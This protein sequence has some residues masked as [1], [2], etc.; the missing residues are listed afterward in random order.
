[1]PLLD[2]DPFLGPRDAGED[3]GETDLAVFR[4]V[5]G[6]GAGVDEPSQ[7]SFERGPR[8]IAFLEFF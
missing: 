1:M 4:E 8:A 3:F 7:E 2:T 6:E 5:D